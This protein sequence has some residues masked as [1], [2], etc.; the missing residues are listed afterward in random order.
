MEEE[1]GEGRGLKMDIRGWQR[2]RKLKAPFNISRLFESRA[3]AHTHSWQGCQ[4]G[5]P[6]N[7]NKHKQT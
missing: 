3:H 2:R 4:L 7:T 1:G 6:D 5:E